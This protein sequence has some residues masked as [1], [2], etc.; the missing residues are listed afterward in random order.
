MGIIGDLILGGLVRRHNRRSNRISTRL[1]DFIPDSGNIVVCGGKTGE[2]GELATQIKEDIFYK[3]VFDVLSKSSEYGEPGIAICAPKS[4]SAELHEDFTN[5]AF[6]NAKTPMVYF[7]ENTSFIPFDNTASKQQVATMF[8][9]VLKKKYGENDSVT[10][11]LEALMNKLLTYLIQGLGQRR[12]TY[13]NLSIIVS[14]LIETNDSYGN[15]ST[16]KG[17]AD[18][19]DWVE[20]NLG[21]N[22]DGFNENFFVNSWD[23]V[24]KKFYNFWSMYSSQ[25]NKLASRNGKKRSLFSC[26]QKGEVCMMEISYTNDDLLIETVLSEIESFSE[27]SRRICNLIGMNTPATGF[28]KYQLLDLNRSVFIG[29]TFGGLD[30]Q[31]CN[32]PDPTVVCLGVSARDAKA[33]F[34][35]MVSTSNWVDMHLG[36]APM[37]RGSHAE[38]AIVQKEPIP[39]TVLTSSKIRDGG[40]YILSKNGYTHVDYLY[41]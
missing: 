12:F 9:R 16:S 18:F 7:G 15:N 25:I 20:S 8:S 32:I 14:H 19:L 21:I 6:N 31:D 27:E 29:N 40:G 34:E 30:L 10:S 33:I 23:V 41:V 17:L 36:F 3:C 38:L 11:D 35:L 5:L 2:D 37:G 22:T 28:E 1:F 39:T 13:Y 26:L 4:V 24:I